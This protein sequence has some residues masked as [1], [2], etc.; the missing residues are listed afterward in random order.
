ME[1]RTDNNKRLV[2]NTFA[3][4]CRTAVVMV[5]SLIVTRYLLNVLGADDYGL[6][7]VVASVV[8]LFSFLNASMTQAIQRF[9]TFEIGRD[10]KDAFTRVYSMSF[11]TQFLM[12]VLLIILCEAIGV[13]YINC[14]LNIDPDRLVAA[15]WAFQFSILTFCINFLR[16]P[17]ESSVIAYEKMSFFAYVS[18][19]DALLK[20]GLVYLLSIAPAD[21][22]ISYAA[23]LAAE[24]LLVFLAYR[25]YCRYIFDACR[26]KFIWDKHLLVEMLSFSGWT[27]CSSATDVLTQNGVVL[28]LNYYVS[29]VANAA[30][31]IANQVSAAVKSF[32]AGFQ[33]SFRPQIVKAYAQND[34]D[35]LNA[36]ITKTS[37][38]SFILVCLPAVFLII[39]APL[40]LRIWLTEV[41]EYT[42]SFCRLL[43]ICSIID[44]VSGPYNCAIMA[45]GKIRNYQIA[46]S[47]S[48][49]LDFVLCWVA[50][51][52]GV[53]AHQILIFRV[54]T[55]GVFNMILGL[56][57]LKS[58]I[59]FG[60]RDYVRDVFGPILIFILLFIPLAIFIT[61]YFDDWTLFIISSFFCVVIGG[62]L[63]LFVVL[64]KSERKY[65]ISLVKR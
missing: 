10:D 5:V 34:S 13:W 8:V 44:G 12:I 61:F 27:V 39:N 37:K 1:S 41:P 65:I 7:N 4:Y 55:R 64:K 20:L 29:L 14:K 32:V 26:F 53:S 9:L 62:L 3:L 21:K 58:L 33:T 15:N 17:Y 54:L 11:I 35:Y 47:I 57:F 43:L 38:I 59:G 16:V 46:I 25:F 19:L 22:L 63:S 31:G 50:L 36:L 2:K 60:L 24:T 45:T 18:I 52:A 30:M 48:F 56:F 6:Y 49:L 51:K 40:I 28:L 42:V 23:L